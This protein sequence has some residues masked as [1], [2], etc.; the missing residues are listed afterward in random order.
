MVRRVLGGIDCDP[1]SNFLAQKNVQAAT[2]YTLADNG[3][4]HP[5]YGR[6]FLNGPY[7]DLLPWVRKLLEEIKLGHVS[8]AIMLTNAVTD[9]EW[10]SLALQ[11]CALVCFTEGRIRFLD[12]NGALMGTPPSQGQAFFYF[13]G[14]VG[15]F[16][17]EFSRIG[18]CCHL[19]RRNPALKNSPLEPF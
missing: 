5:W 19:S 3:L 12:K 16:K 7:D 2:F 1:A 11:G 13:G 9:T 17:A 18:N 8:S 15:R 4:V 14:D 6:T 10:F